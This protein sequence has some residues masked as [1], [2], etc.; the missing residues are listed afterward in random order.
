MTPSVGPPSPSLTPEQARQT[1]DNA[2]EQL[3]QTQFTAAL[4][5]IQAAGASRLNSCYIEGDAQVLNMLTLK[6]F[7]ALP[8]WVKAVVT[9]TNDRDP[10]GETMREVLKSEAICISLDNSH[11]TGFIQNLWN[12]AFY[13]KT[14]YKEMEFT[15][16]FHL[17]KELNS[18]Q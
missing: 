12:S 16:E 4:E 13:H 11:K 8:C 14:I 18:K 17:F 9:L 7:N 2:V 1:L 10:Y 6:G 3:H 5:A 15:E